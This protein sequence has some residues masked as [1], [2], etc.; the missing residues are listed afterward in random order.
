MG[1]CKLFD[2]RNLEAYTFEFSQ[3]PN[4]GYNRR[5]F[6]DA[7]I[8]DLVYWIWIDIIGRETSMFENNIEAFQIIYRD[9]D[10]FRLPSYKIMFFLGIFDSM[11]LVAHFLTGIF[12]ISQTTWFY[13]FKKVS[14][15]NYSR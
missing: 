11:Q 6:H 13:F 1:S 4:F 2:S 3:N 7:I 5:G 9:K 8:V 12:T 15:F 10:L 14:R